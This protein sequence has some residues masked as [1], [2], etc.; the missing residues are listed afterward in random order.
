MI[1]PINNVGTRPKSS[2][3][4][5]TEKITITSTDKNFSNKMNTIALMHYSMLLKQHTY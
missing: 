2:K 1:P 5:Y 4:P 3:K